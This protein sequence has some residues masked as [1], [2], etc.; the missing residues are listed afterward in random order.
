LTPFFLMTSQKAMITKSPPL[1]FFLLSVRTKR[2][3]LPFLCTRRD[4]PRISGRPLLLSPSFPR[5]W[6]SDYLLV[7]TV[8]CR[9]HRLSF[10]LC[11]RY[12]TPAGF[13]P[14]SLL[15]VRI[16]TTAEVSSLR[17]LPF[18]FSSPCFRRQTWVFFPFL[19]FG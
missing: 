5:E 9:G 11:D 14:L 13:F 15:D 19:L 4:R 6:V 10:G 2:V 8:S 18:F 1:F 17:E 7:I 16:R 3:D 12:T